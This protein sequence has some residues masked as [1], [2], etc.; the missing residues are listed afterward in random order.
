M[1]FLGNFFILAI[2]KEALVNFT[3]DDVIDHFQKMKTRLE[4]FHNVEVS[5]PP[6]CST[7]PETILCKNNVQCLE[8]FCRYEQIL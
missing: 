1:Y 6:L 5:G 2:E 8:I 4:Q 7:Y 3:N